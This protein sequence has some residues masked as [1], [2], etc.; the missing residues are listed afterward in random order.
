MEEILNTRKIFKLNLWINKEK[1]I[2]KYESMGS[3][4]LKLKKKNS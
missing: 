1:I 3:Y 2:R 4:F